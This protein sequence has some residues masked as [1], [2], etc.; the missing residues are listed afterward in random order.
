M[1]VKPSVSFE[2]VTCKDL[3]LF[4]F[5]IVA[6]AGNSKLLLKWNSSHSP[7]LQQFCLLSG[8]AMATVVLLPASSK[9]DLLNDDTYRLD[10]ATVITLHAHAR[11]GVM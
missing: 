9:V 7:V 11:A 4:L 5:Y 6:I 2:F 10:S 3:P 8:L 1:N